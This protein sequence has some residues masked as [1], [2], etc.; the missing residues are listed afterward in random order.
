MNGGRPGASQSP[1][2]GA[3]RASPTGDPDRGRF[4]PGA[5]VADRYR[6]VALVGRGGMG[7]VYRADDLKLGQSVALKFL[8]ERVEKDPGRLSRLLNEVK[9]ARQ[10]SHP[11]VCRVYDVFDEAGRH[12][13]SMEFVDGEDLAALLRR[14][15]HLP[16]EKAIQIARQLCAG[17]AAAHEQGVLH[18]DLKPANVMIDGRGRA[19]ITDF[20]LARLAGSDGGEGALAGTPAYMAPEQLAGGEAT[21]RSDL[22]SLGLVLYELFTGRMAFKG[23]TPEAVRRLQSQTPPASPSEVMQGFDPAVERIILRCLETEARHRPASALAVAVALPG[24]DPLAAA[25]AAGETPSPELVAEAGEVGGLHAAGA[26]ACLAGLIVAFLLTV[27]L[28]PQTELIGFVSLPKPTEYLGERAQEIARRL[29]YPGPARDRIS[30]FD[31]DQG[32]MTHLADADPTSRRWNRLSAEVPGIIYFWYRESPAYMDP[33]NELAR[34]PTYEDPPFTLPGMLSVQIDPTGNLRRFEAIPPERDDS[35]GDWPQPDWSRC[36]AESGLDFKAFRSVEPVWTPPVF[37]D[38]RAAWEGV[39]ADVSQTPIRAEA[40]GYHGRPVFFR[41][42]EPWVRPSSAPAEPTG[43]W[44]TGSRI[45]S[46]VMLFAALL[47]GAILA[48]RNIRLGRGDRKGAG[49]LA[50]FVLISD[51]IAWFLKAHHAPTG[52]T[53]W[54]LIIELAFPLLTGCLVWLAYMALEPHVRRLWPHMV[55][56]WVRLLD[57]RFRDPLVGRDVLV[58]A[59]AGTV[60]GLMERLYVMLPRWLDLSAPVPDRHDPRIGFILISLRGLRYSVGNMIGNQVPTLFLPLMYVVMLLMLRILLRRQ[61]A[62]V[63]AFL[64]L[65]LVGEPSGANPYVYITFSL[66][67]SAVIVV[68]LLRF[69]L[70]ALVVGSTVLTFM[71]CYP[72]TP[73]LTSWYSGNT[74]LV[75]LV[76][77]ALAAY[78]LRLSL[79]AR[80]IDPGTGPST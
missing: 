39:S 27:L 77:A 4:L 30:G 12:F 1:H 14:I 7:E 71:I 34:S 21:V 41:I 3:E 16:R 54:R 79:P 33:Q 62:A 13:I 43:H 60:F 72:F 52:M 64:L 49:R 5:I 10:I 47:G 61:G 25:L 55:V 9:I 51:Y 26:V 45:A 40:A 58:G 50:L 15:G 56:S 65:G 36:F 57:G 48:R 20:G 23:D 53:M 75:A 67:L 78:G 38:T 8:P 42:I 35:R 66:L 59:T 69:G 22:Y 32:A 76:L 6:I 74:L 28:S 80:T 29:G 31:F 17:L 11:N 70:L 24:G 63:A 18:R 2:A 44:E 37:A 19:R 73:D 68:L 46:G